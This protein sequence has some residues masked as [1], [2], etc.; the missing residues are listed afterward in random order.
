MIPF[1]EHV[2]RED[3]GKTGVE[4]SG[5]TNKLWTLDCDHICLNVIFNFVKLL[6][7]KCF[8]TSEI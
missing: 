8:L 1:K 3:D 5:W 2:V 4:H 7:V 6:C